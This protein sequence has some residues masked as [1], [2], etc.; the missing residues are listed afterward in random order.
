MGLYGG[1]T[2]DYL[3]CKSAHRPGAWQ[4]LPCGCLPRQTLLRN[5]EPGHF[6]PARGAS[7]SPVRS[8]S[9]RAA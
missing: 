1:G 4:T 9:G 6:E 2:P 8:L 7:A 5:S 3:A